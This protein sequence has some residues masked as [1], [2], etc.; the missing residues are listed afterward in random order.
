MIPY[1]KFEPDAAAQK[2]TIAIGLGKAQ[3]A[4]CAPILTDILLL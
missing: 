3:A 2:T 1:K 4:Y